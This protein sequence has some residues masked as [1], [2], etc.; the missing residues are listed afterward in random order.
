MS[1][2]AHGSA[3]QNSAKLRKLQY[4]L[5]RQLLDE[6]SVELALPDGITLEIGIVQE[7]QNGIKKTDDYCYVMASRDGKATILD[8]YNLGVQ[9]V[10][11]EN[12]IICEDEMM[13]D[14]GTVVETLDVV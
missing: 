1:N 13:I 3:E 14:D 4:L 12:T 11:D 10:P 2:K 5:I 7:D 6:G 9:F 8:S